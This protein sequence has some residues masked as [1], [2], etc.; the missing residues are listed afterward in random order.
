MMTEK[1]T[2]DLGEKKNLT[3]NQYLFGPVPSRRFGRSLGVDLV[4]YKTCSFDCIFCQLGPTT[5]KTVTRREYVPVDR[6]IAELD[7]WIR[8]GAEADYITLSGSG[9]P[10]L[11]AGFGKIIDYVHSH[12]AIPAVLLTNGALLN[13]PDV[14]VQ[15]AKADVVK[16]SLSAWD[17]FSLEHMN[18]PHH[19]ITFENII[20]G[21]RR[22][23][24]NLHGQLWMEV[25]LVWGTNTTDQ[26][27]SAIASWAQT[28]HPDKIQLNTSVRPPCEEYAWAV[29]QDHMHRLA[30]LF[31]PTAEVIAEYNKDLMES[32]QTDENAIHQMLRRRPCTLDDICKS[33]G[34]HRNQALKYL[35]KLMRNDQIYRIRQKDGDYFAAR[36][37]TPSS[38]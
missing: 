11:H 35:G 26:D 5:H 17:P 3:H 38:E 14:R 27:V 16:V 15:A 37:D 10:T 28:I 36:G 8:S 30:A 34:L 7:T 20:E 33:F 21:Q 1:K 24:D 2:T 32:I 18:R 25:F 19:D 29:P 9:E 13:D 22:L 31:T 12:T 4:P 6:V 23:R